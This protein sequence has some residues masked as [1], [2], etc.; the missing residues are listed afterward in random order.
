VQLEVL[1]LLPPPP[2]L[3]A[4]TLIHLA[5]SRGGA[6]VARPLSTWFLQTSASAAAHAVLSWTLISLRIAVAASAAR[7]EDMAVRIRALTLATP[8]RARRV[9]LLAPPALAA[10]G[11]FH[12]RVGAGCRLRGMR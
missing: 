8:G 9:L 3:E 4:I 7:D 5:A 6:R 10:A 11:E 12:T 2:P 1:L